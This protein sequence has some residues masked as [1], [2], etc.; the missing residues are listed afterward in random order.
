MTYNCNIIYYYIK[1]APTKFSESTEKAAA[2]V[3]N[4][5]NFNS[6]K[7]N[8]NWSAPAPSDDDSEIELCIAPA[9]VIDDATNYCIP[10]S[11]IGISVISISIPTEWVSG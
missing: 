1:Y 7:S 6:I 4:D 5:I 3:F 8:E 9:E 11:N 2:S 10:I